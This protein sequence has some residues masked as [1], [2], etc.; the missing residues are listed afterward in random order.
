MRSDCFT[1]RGLTVFVDIE[2]LPPKPPVSDA[3][4]RTDVHIPR[5]LSTH[6]DELI[7]QGP[8]ARLKAGPS[9]SALQSFFFPVSF[10]KPLMNTQY[11]TSSFEELV[12]LRTLNCGRS[13][14]PVCSGSG[15]HLGEWSILVH[16]RSLAFWNR[17]KPRSGR[18]L[19]NVS[20]SVIEESTPAPFVSVIF[21]P[22][23]EELDVV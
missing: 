6:N 1:I 16:S 15:N 3:I 14:C 13:I 10:C 17:L 11:H 4:D 12:F 8:K 18:H 22:V 9:K 23:E 7:L 21:H 20:V 19:G 5:S 2:F